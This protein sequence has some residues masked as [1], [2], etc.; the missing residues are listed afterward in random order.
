MSCDCPKIGVEW[1]L[2]A[3]LVMGWSRIWDVR[4]IINPLSL[5]SVYE[6]VSSSFCGT[7]FISKVKC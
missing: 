6:L 4:D 2:M 3:L 7:I 1:R 5:L